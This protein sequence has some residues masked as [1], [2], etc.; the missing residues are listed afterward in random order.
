[1]TLLFCTLILLCCV[2]VYLTLRAT[3]VIHFGTSMILLLTVSTATIIQSNPWVQCTMTG[4][5]VQNCC[6]H[7]AHMPIPEGR[8][9]RPCCQ[10]IE[11]VGVMAHQNLSHIK[12][13]DYHATIFQLSIHS[14]KPIYRFSQRYKSHQIA[15]A[16]PDR[17]F[18]LSLS[19]IQRYLL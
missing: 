12:I 14:T 10:Q 4:L 18:A 16:P 2:G 6:C 3:R 8:W 9:Q 19:Q 11:L 5:M 13:K 7:Q 15:R 17:I 1:M